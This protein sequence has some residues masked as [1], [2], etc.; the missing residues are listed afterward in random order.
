MQIQSYIKYNRIS[1]IK[2]RTLLSDIR[3]LTPQ[4]ATDKLFLMQDR[5]AKMLHRAIKSAITSANSANYEGS[6]LVFKEIIVEAG[7]S[8]K[9]FRAG[10]RGMASPYKRPTSHIKIILT[11]EKVTEEKVV[12]KPEKKEVK[13]KSIKP[14]K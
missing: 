10:S 13:V 5:S 2:L 4:E 3:K 6:S 7:P 14:N 12:N 9:R 1:P 11:G 8:F